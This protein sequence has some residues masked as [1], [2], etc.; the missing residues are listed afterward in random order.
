MALRSGRRRERGVV[1]CAVARDDGLAFVRFRL[2]PL[3]SGCA[4]R[5]YLGR[6][7]GDVRADVDRSV[8]EFQAAPRQ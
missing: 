8:E 2:R 4:M 5:T 1:A 3:L 6:G 7:V